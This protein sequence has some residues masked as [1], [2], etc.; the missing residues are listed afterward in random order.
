M[1]GMMRREEEGEASAR[2]VD[3]VRKEVFN[4]EGGGGVRN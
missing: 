2:C 1:P 3:C 4:R